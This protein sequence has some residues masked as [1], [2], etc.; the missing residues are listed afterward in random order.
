MKGLKTESCVSLLKA[1]PEYFHEYAVLI[2]HLMGFAGG[3]LAKAGAY[4]NSSAQ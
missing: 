2:A 3:D 4:I 1:K